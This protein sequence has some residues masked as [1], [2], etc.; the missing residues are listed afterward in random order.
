MTGGRGTSWGWIEITAPPARRVDDRVTEDDATEL[1]ALLSLEC[2]WENA[3]RVSVP[4]SSEYRA[5][6]IARAKGEPFVTAS[7]YWD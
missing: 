7:P 3:R 1:R 4:A 5:E 6:Y 2:R